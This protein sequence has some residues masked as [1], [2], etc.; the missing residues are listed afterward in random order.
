MCF[1]KGTFLIQ[2]KKLVL[3]ERVAASKIFSK[4]GCLLGKSE[5]CRIKKKP[6]LLASLPFVVSCA[7]RLAL[8]MVFVH[9]T[10][11]SDLR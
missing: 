7:A 11:N 1:R 3:G 4:T 8:N 6:G 5:A 10:A 9:G 2:A